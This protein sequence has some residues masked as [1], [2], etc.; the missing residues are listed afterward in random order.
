MT[1]KF[2][3][4]VQCIQ[5]SV[6]NNDMFTSKNILLV[7]FF[8]ELFCFVSYDYNTYVG[9]GLVLDW[10]DRENFVQQA[11]MTLTLVIDVGKHLLWLFNSSSIWCY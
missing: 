11:Q 1:F 3:Y 9:R 6:P 2:E 4:I 8:T 7:Y 5:L 10:L